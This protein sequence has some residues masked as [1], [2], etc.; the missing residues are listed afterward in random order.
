MRYLKLQLA[1]SFFLVGPAATQLARTVFGYPILNERGAP[2]TIETSLIAVLSNP[3]SWDGEL[4][5][6]DGWFRAS[7]ASGGL[8]LSSEYC[9]RQT[10]QYGLKI[11]YSALS[12]EMGQFYRSECTFGSVQGMFRAL[13]RERQVLPPGVSEFQPI[14]PQPGVVEAKFLTLEPIDNAEQ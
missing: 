3:D 5:S 14:A 13:P 9:T 8:F 11:D 10:L 1:L 4:I 2:A 6:I 7:Y 12:E